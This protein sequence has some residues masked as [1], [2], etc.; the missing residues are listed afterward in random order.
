MAAGDEPRALLLTVLQKCVSHLKFNPAIGDVRELRAVA[1]RSTAT[2]V[3]LAVAIPNSLMLIYSDLSQLVQSRLADA[4]VAGTVKGYLSEFQLALVAGASCSL[5]QRKEFARPIV[6]P[7]IDTLREFTPAMQSPADFV[8][9][10]GLPVLDQACAAQAF[11]R[12]TPGA[13]AARDRRNRLSH[14]LATLQ[15]CLQRTLGHAAGGLSL[16]GVWSDYVEDLAPALLLLVRCL[17]ALW[18]P[19]HWR[20]MPWQSAQ[21]QS[22][23]FGVLEMSTAERQI[24]VS[25]AYDAAGDSTQTAAAADLWRPRRAPYTTR[26]ELSA[27]TRT[28]AWAVDEPARAVQCSAHA[29]PGLQLHGC[30]FATL[31]RWPR[32]IGASC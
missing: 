11:R 24:I 5:P 12:R 13:G 6:Q 22:A 21:A 29:G 32:A 25:G 15:I 10:L 18:N 7:I 3:R 28:A 2:L 20:P 26:L 17:H 23:L 16:A 9:F 4:R 27:T 30:L 1:R 8:S 31:R 14:V 19:A